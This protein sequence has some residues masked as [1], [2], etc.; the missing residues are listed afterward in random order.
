MKVKESSYIKNNKPLFKKL[1]DEL[2]K[3]YEDASVFV[4]DSIGKN[5][6]V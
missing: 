3:R 5:Y 2:L 1:V 6:V 4:N